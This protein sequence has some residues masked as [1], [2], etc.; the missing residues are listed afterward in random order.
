MSRGNGTILHD[1]PN[2]GRIRSPEMNIGGSATAIGD[3][4]LEKQGYTLV[5]SGWE[6]DLTSGLRIT[7]PVAR[8]RDGSE[9]T[10]RVRSEYILDTPESTQ[11]VTAPPAYE[12]V[13]T[14]N[15]DATLTM[16]VHQDDTKVTIPRSDWA[17]ADCRSLAF[18]GV[19]DRRSA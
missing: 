14:S 3:G 6:I 15:A 10:G 13:S 4:F 19:P 11:D 5:D 16:R 8:N 17:F 12:A 7:V 18:P 1:V 2:R 9:I